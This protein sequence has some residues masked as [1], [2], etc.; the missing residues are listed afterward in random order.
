[1]ATIVLLTG[2]CWSAALALF[3]LLVL[4]PAPALAQLP[5]QPPQL[6][7]GTNCTP[8][9]TVQVSA[10]AAPDVDAAQPG[11]QVRI[12]MKVQ[13]SGVARVERQLA[14]CEITES[15]A[16]VTWSLTFTPPGGAATSASSGHAADHT[17]PSTTSFS[18][19]SR[20]RDLDRLWLTGPDHVRFGAAVSA[21]G[22]VGGGGK[23]NFARPRR[24]HRIWPAHRLHRCRGH[25]QSSDPPG[26]ASSCGPTPTLPRAWHAGPASGCLQQLTVCPNYFWCR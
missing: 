9:T 2:T 26:V 21:A 18:P 8:Q 22:S 19:R 25:R 5:P 20:K 6:P 17:A 7:I 13:V 16:A 11:V 23:L 15:L 4:T 3:A 1:L 14:N 24:R 12:G 10:T